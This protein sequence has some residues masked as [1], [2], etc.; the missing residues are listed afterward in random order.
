MA[1]GLCLHRGWLWLGRMTG[2]SEW[3]I[4][5]LLTLD[6]SSVKVTCECRRARQRA[7]QKDFL[8]ALTTLHRE[9]SA[10]WGSV[11]L[12]GSLHQ[13]SSPLLLPDP[14]SPLY[15]KC[16]PKLLGTLPSSSGLFSPLPYRLVAFPHR[17]RSHGFLLFEATLQTLP[18]P[19][20]AWH[21]P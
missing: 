10:I 1:S 8:S 9:K 6:F 20:S 12:W 14:C 17:I 15:P 4:L 16:F 18:H 7:K 5:I 19:Q 2:S 3:S 21:A 13:P 11:S